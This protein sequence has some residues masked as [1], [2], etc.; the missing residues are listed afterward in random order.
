MFREIFPQTQ[1]KKKSKT[2]MHSECHQ[3]FVSAFTSMTSGL[4]FFS[5]KIYFENENEF[6]QKG[7][8]IYFFL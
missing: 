5:R 1:K 8:K 4:H 6:I 3:I 2:E 7:R